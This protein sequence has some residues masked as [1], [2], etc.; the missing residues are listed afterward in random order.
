M[1]AEQE[2]LTRAGLRHYV[3]ARPG[4]QLVAEV[5]DAAHA[6]DLAC[7][8]RPDVLICDVD[9]APVGGVEV[10]TRLRERL[11]ED[12]PSVL[13]LGQRLTNEQ[14]V[15]ALA[16]KAGGILDKRSSPEVLFAAV[17]SAS[18]GNVFVSPP[19]ITQLFKNYILLPAEAGESAA[20][21]TQSLTAR[22][23]AVLRLIAHGLSNL[24]IAGRLHLA[25]ATVK[26]YSSHLFEKLG[27]RDRLQAALIAIGAGLAPS[28]LGDP[29][30]GDS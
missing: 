6:V 28:A 22:E 11:E 15:A 14:L 10:V 21:I 3:D 7:H 20:E 24:E 18:E 25:E 4:V 23:L 30:L 13:L 27:A 8:V 12:A 5:T 29:V 9:L 17:D 19:F 2:D 1:V 26:A 16:A